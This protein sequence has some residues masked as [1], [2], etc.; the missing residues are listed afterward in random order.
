M[1][2]KTDLTAMK[3]YF[4]PAI[5]ALIFS[6]GSI[7][8]A[9]A[10]KIDR[11]AVV[12][13]LTT[14]DPEIVDYFPRWKVCEPDLMAQ[15]YQYFVYLNYPKTQLDR[16]NI[17][18]LAAPREYADLPYDILLIK[19][20][21]SSMNSVDIQGIMSD[22]LIGFLSGEYVYSGLDKGV[23]ADVPTRD[24]CYEDVP[25][26][27]KINDDQKAAIIDY[28]KPT[29]V[30]HAFTVSLFEQ[31]LKIGD[32]GF[33]LRSIVGTDEIGYPFWSSGESKIVLQRP[34]Y[35]NKDTRTSNAI[36]YLI[37]AHLGASYRIE[38]GLDGNN[39]LSW[40]N[41]RKLNSVS[42][43]KIVGGLD[44]YMPFHP[45]AGIHLNAE[46]PIEGIGT[47]GIDVN[48]HGTYPKFINWKPDD[49]RTDRLESVAPVL[50]AT[51]QLTFFY[52]WWLDPMNPE[53]YFRFDVGISYAEV[54][55]A[56]YYEEETETGIKRYITDEGVEGLEMFKPNDFADWF[57]LKV[58][59]RNQDVF[60]FGASMQLSNQIFLGRVYIPLFGNWL[61]LEGKY[62]TPIRDARPYETPNFFM[63]SPV[64]RL[65]I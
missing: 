1:K 45:E 36:P 48:S 61:Y 25:K 8:G 27:I 58:E 59:Y 60:P 32:S 50:Q 17:E 4:L 14:L 21:E 37:N 9:K 10:Q 31:S 43:G 42:T 41:E 26:E 19:C 52:N 49:P 11:Q 57:Y 6:V 20:G 7:S 35:I 56:A 44:F 65:T 62:A 2:I 30:T 15:I 53:N 33:W 46:I 55:E 54:Q 24:Y 64:I 16:Q 51:G 12:D 23:V 47:H 29:N 3:K 5:I 22:L 38:S 63:I 34:L 40:V 18:V 39:L 28:L 13:S